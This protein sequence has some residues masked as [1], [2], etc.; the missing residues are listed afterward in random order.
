MKRMSPA[1]EAAPKRRR[2]TSP[3]RERGSP[4]PL[5]EKSTERVSYWLKSLPESPRS[6]ASPDAAVE[7]PADPAASARSQDDASRSLHPS[8]SLPDPYP[9]DLGSQEYRIQVLRRLNI[10]VDED[11]PDDARQRLL[12][13]ADPT[14]LDVDRIAAAACELH[15]GARALLDR[16]TASGDEWTA[17]LSQAL[18]AL[19][20]D[21]PGRLCC[22]PKRSWQTAVKPVTHIHHIGPPSPQKRRSVPTLTHEPPRIQS[23][24]TP[25]HTN[26][27]A[28]SHPPPA[29]A[30]HR[31][32]PAPAPAPVLRLE[33][34][35]P[36]LQPKT[37]RPDLSIGLSD[38][39]AAWKEDE[40]AWTRP[41]LRGRDVRE[42]L[43]DLQHGAAHQDSVTLITDP[44]TASP[45][46]L[47]FPFLTVEAK[48]ASSASITDAENLAA[49][50]A[51]CALRILAELSKPPSEPAPSAAHS[52]LQLRTFSLT[53]E[54][55]AHV[56]WAHVPAA[57]GS[58]MIWLG[59]YRITHR[60]SALDLVRNLALI[61]HWGAGD[62]A[63]WVKRQCVQFIDRILNA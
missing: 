27:P 8:D 30:A 58:H 1:D 59:A 33:P 14:R 17:L 24:P 6:L 34:A 16:P 52:A 41:G 15:D 38:S 42:I 45:S 57:K 37:P 40:Q 21:V 53:C 50:S 22:V 51:A 62:F 56:L 18:H 63:D 5:R 47:R 9:A 23:Y 36:R 10:A 3:L 39:D 20:R 25:D 7:A 61:L 28:Q 49:V 26:S 35:P 48:A 4:E 12:P 29:L 55:P 19:M 44:C 31:T 43:A 2:Q 54:G 60:A 46:G 11:V 13:P 32:D